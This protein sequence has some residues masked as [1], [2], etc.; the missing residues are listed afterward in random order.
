MRHLSGKSATQNNLK[1]TFVDVVRPRV[2]MTLLSSEPFPLK[3]GVLRTSALIPMGYEPARTLPHHNLFFAGG[4]LRRCHANHNSFLR[5]VILAI[6]TCRASDREHEP[7][8]TLPPE[9][10]LCHRTHYLGQGYTTTESKWHHTPMTGGHI[11][12]DLR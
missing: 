1:E 12:W 11:K 5:R 6:I 2:H 10:C 9:G 8:V 4:L 3:D 7:V